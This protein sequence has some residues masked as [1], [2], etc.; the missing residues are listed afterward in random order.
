MTNEEVALALINR[1]ELIFN[2]VVDDYAKL[3]WAVASTI[4]NS[5]TQQS[6]MDIE[7]IV[8]D[9]FIQLWQKPEKY[10]PERGSLKTYLAIKTR[11]LAL[12]RLKKKQRDLHDNIDD[13]TLSATEDTL[14]GKNTLAWQELYDV[15]MTM[16]EPTKEILIRRFFYE[17]KPAE[18]RNI[19][20]L[21]AK[22]IDNALYR[23]KKQIQK[24]LEYTNFFREVEQY[25]N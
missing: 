16:E 15:I 24:Q 13:L 12:N 23:G 25:D 11:S 4:I 1:D 9:V 14:D 2:Q 5:R 3:L 22:T 19:M 17:M 7:E 18:I 8:N 20:S 6:I 10:Q 21:P